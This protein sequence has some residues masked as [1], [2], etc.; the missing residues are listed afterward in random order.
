MPVAGLGFHQKQQLRYATVLQP[1][2]NAYNDGAFRSIHD[3]DVRGVSNKDRTVRLSSFLHFPNFRSKKK[4]KGPQSD[5]LLAE[6]TP[7]TD[8]GDETEKPE[9]VSSEPGGVKELETEP[10]AA[11]KPQEVTAEVDDR[12]ETQLLPDDTL[13]SAIEPKSEG[14]S[15]EY[16]E[17][18]EKKQ[19]Q[20][21]LSKPSLSEEDTRNGLEKPS[22]LKG[23]DR[24]ETGEE[25][26]EEQPQPEDAEP[27]EKLEDTLSEG[28]YYGSGPDAFYFSEKLG[29]YPFS[30]V[31]NEQELKAFDPKKVVGKAS[32]VHCAGSQGYCQFSVKE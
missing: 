4:S 15:A 20:K 30:C 25:K 1:V 24:G 26:A 6:E 14:G 32:P 21:E 22:D 17:P 16:L 28:T 10:K 18:S 9:E 23:V 8:V 27:L 5:V 13:P 19:I 29:D 2:S 12:S 7:A 31:C 11:Q 3:N